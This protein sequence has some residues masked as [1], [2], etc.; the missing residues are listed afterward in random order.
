MSL[1]NLMIKLNHLQ[2]QHPQSSHASSKADS[3]IE[4]AVNE[5]SSVKRKLR[6]EY[7]A[8]S[9]NNLTVKA[10]KQVAKEKKVKYQDILSKI[11]PSNNISGDVT[12]DK[13]G[14][15]GKTR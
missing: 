7:G 6:K 13:T 9:D 4:D 2:G 8:A 5:V 11:T 1:D 14:K 12:W 10:A 15:L 3:S